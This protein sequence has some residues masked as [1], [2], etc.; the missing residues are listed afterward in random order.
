GAG[1]CLGL[2][3]REGLD[4]DHITRVD[5]EGVVYEGRDASLEPTRARYATRRQVRT[6][7]DAIRGAD[8]FLG[9]SAANLLS[10]AMVASMGPT[11]LI[12]ALANPDP[13]IRPEIAQAVRPD[14]IVATGR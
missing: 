8:V 3:V 10:A 7:A 5:S 4:H 6:L 12:L 9:C 13:E 14:C 2:L 11:P 1:A